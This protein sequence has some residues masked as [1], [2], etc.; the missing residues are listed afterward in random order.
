M[1]YQDVPKDCEWKAWKTADGTWEVKFED[2]FGD[3][4]MHLVE[5]DGEQERIEDETLYL[6][7][8]D[9]ANTIRWIRERKGIDMG[10][11]IV[12]ANYFYIRPDGTRRETQH[13]HT[14]LDLD[15]Q[16]GRYVA[17]TPV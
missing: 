6:D 15:V 5:D 14:H 2:R 11:G 7:V 17:L 12:D 16:E 1:D 4:K 9:G 10:N 13:N 8:D 3:V